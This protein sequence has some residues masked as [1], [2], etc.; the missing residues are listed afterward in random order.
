MAQKQT[1]KDFLLERKQN[2]T[3]L[4]TMHLHINTHSADC[5]TPD[6][7][8]NELLVQMTL[9]SDHQKC[10]VQDV[11]VTNSPWGD[12]LDKRLK[13]PAEKYEN[14]I[15]SL[16]PGQIVDLNNP[17]LTELIFQNLQL[18]QA[19]L[20]TKDKYYF[21]EDIDKTKKL[22]SKDGYSYNKLFQ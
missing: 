19:I 21:F 11:K 12:S 9:K 4:L 13:D 2:N 17:Q 6:S 22:D 3:H 15:F 14:I 18:K 16:E 5:G 1:A 20:L 7:F 8:G 10:N